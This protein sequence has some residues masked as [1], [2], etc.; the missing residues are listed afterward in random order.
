MIDRYIQ[1]Q[2]QNLAYAGSCVPI[3]WLRQRVYKSQLFA[4][5]MVGIDEADIMYKAAWF[6][7][8]IFQTEYQFMTTAWSLSTDWSRRRVLSMFGSANHLPKEEKEGQ[9]PDLVI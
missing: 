1:V 9:T 5:A 8:E 6:W 7:T 2:H 4:C 3:K